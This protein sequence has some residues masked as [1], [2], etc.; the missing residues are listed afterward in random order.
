VVVEAS[1]KSG[2]LITAACAAEQG[3][4]VMA[5]P[6]NVLSGRNRGSHSL[7]K[8]GAK[9]VESSDDILEELGMDPHS[10]S[11]AAGSPLRDDAVLH[12]MA[13]GESY[14]LDQ[15]AATTGLDGRTI[16]ARLAE[17]ELEGRVR[18]AHGGRFVRRGTAVL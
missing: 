2:S 11:S 12:A 1:E 14:E 10:A 16:L 3:R 13:E 17:L 9:I 5:V 7:L 8:D 6:G 4:E 18:R 15:L